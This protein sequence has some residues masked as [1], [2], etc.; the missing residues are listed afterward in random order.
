MKTIN[1]RIKKIKLNVFF[2]I[3]N[4]FE[5]NP[6][7]TIDNSSSVVVNYRKS[8][9][10]NHS[11]DKNKEKKHIKPDENKIINKDENK[12][13]NIK[14]K[15]KNETLLNNLNKKKFIGEYSRY[16]QV[17]KIKEENEGDESDKGKTKTNKD[18]IEIENK[19]NNDYVFSKSKYKSKRCGNIFESNK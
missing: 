17:D 12:I 11:L 18:K 4:F 15:S 7:S 5:K 8:N 10:E 6:Q 1:K 14:K 9:H 19:P 16:F 3:I 13:E 2:N